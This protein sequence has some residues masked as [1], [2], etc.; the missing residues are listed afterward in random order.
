MMSCGKS[1]KIDSYIGAGIGLAIGLCSR[2]ITGGFRKSS[3]GREP[4]GKTDAS[5]ARGRAAYIAVAA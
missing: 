3:T 4:S 1:G 2:S 5:G